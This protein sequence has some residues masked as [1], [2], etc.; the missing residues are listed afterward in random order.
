MNA[1]RIIKLAPTAL[2]LVFLGYASYSLQASLPGAAERQAALAKGLDLMLQDIVTSDPI[3]ADK[4]GRLRDPFLPVVRAATS[5]AGVEH[6]A[7]AAPEDDPLID[8]VAALN[9]DAT[10]LQG[11]D[12]LAIINGR[13]YK[14]GQALVLAGG[15]KDSQPSLVVLFVKPTGV[16]LRGGNKNYLLGYPDQLGKRSP[17]DKDAVTDPA[18]SAVLD[19]AGQNAMFQRLLGSPIGALGKSLIGGV[20]GQS[21]GSAQRR[22]RRK[23]AQSSGN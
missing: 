9:L 22:S 23:S 5:S 12:Q 19:P 2:V 6:V 20:P 16:I 14:K 21:D 15:D 1:S 3:G 10:F 8:V 18:N 7:V 4:L 11:G 13:F 17:A